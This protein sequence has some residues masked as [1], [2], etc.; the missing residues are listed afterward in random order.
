M[1]ENKVETV[2][3]K[4]TLKE[5]IKAKKKEIG[6][7][8][9]ATTKKAMDWTRENKETVKAVAPIVVAVIGGAA[10]IICKRAGDAKLEREKDLRELYVYDRSLGHYWKLSHALSTKDWRKINERKKDGEKLG[11]ILWDL[12]VLE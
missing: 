6:D 1:E 9:M 7:K 10:K 3:I 12:G 5:K 11:D 8:M 2:E 4:P